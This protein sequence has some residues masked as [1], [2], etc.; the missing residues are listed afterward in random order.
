VQCQSSV[1]TRPATTA[2]STGALAILPLVDLQSA[3]IE[4]GAIQRLHATEQR[5]VWSLQ[6]TQRKDEANRQS[7]PASWFTNF[8]RVAVIDRNARRDGAGQG[9]QAERLRA[10]MHATGTPVTT[11][12]F[13]VR[14]CLTFDVPRAQSHRA[15]SRWDAFPTN[16]TRARER[17]G[18]PW[19][20]PAA[21]CHAQNPRGG[22]DP[23]GDPRV[24]CGRPSALS[25]PC[26][27]GSAD[28]AMSRSVRHATIA[29]VAA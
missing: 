26:I 6:V 11:L 24:I 21:P 7:G 13:R 3:A 23:C 22:T 19:S 4:V 28:T 20:Q 9:G 15:G 2:T 27:P 12:T 29:R 18:S 25:G 17:R 1:P 14:C 8:A 16:L 5:G 10:G